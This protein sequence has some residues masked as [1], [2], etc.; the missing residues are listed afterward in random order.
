AGLLPR[1]AEDLRPAALPRDALL[2]PPGHHPRARLPQPRRGDLLPPRSARRPGRRGR[3]RPLPRQGRS[4]V[5]R[6][7][8]ALLPRAP[9]LPP[10]RGPQVLLEFLAA[11]AA[12]RKRSGEDGV[13]APL[14]Q[15][16]YRS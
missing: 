10:L 12:R 15:E 7:L 14:P 3:R 11:R 6:A 1:G 8:R 16:R 9:R 4:D 13:A 5:P 2:P